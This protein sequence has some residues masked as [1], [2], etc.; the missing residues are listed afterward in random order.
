MGAVGFDF[1]KAALVHVDLGCNVFL[2]DSLD[3]PDGLS[4]L[5]KF[6]DGVFLCKEKGLADFLPI[7]AVIIPLFSKNRPFLQV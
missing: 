3:E 1:S 4:A 2:G 5:P 7:L 6:I